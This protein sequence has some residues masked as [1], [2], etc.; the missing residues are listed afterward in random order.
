MMTLPHMKRLLDIMAQLRNPNGGCPWDVE[1]TFATIA[2]YT[3]EEAYEVAD[4][5]ERHDMAALKEELG[6]LLL[7]V[8]FHSQMA[9]EQG[10]FSFEDVAA[11]INQKMVERH[12]H[13]FGDQQ[14][15]TT[16]DQQTE[17]WENLK[18]QEKERKGQTSV[19]DDVPV[20]FPALT[21]AQKL[22]KKAAK[23]GFDWP[24]LLPVFEKVQEEIIEL[25]EAIA[26][27]N[28]TAIEEELGDL[29]FAVVNIARHTGVDA[30]TALRRANT[31][32]EKRFRYIEPHILP[33][34]SLEEMEGF[35]QEAKKHT[36]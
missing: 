5:I 35:W 21:R 31:K 18:Q 29:L 3:L 6:D 27:Q 30:E 8:V 33:D 9:H 7:Q 20:S 1:Q 36:L 23:K 19:M 14:G 12:P 24:A 26:D 16:A 28:A 4:A 13:V 15:I 11:C 34:S 17:N 25:Q 32:F 22:G 10:L 2:P